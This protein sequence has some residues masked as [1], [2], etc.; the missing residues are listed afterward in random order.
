[1]P[2][3]S[4]TGSLSH[5]P[6]RT[7]NHSKATR[8]LHLP[9]VFSL[10]PR[11]SADHNKH[12]P[13]GKHLLRPRKHSFHSCRQMLCWASC[14]CLRE[15]PFPLERLPFAEVC[16]CVWCSHGLVC[17]VYVARQWKGR[18][19]VAWGRDGSPAGVGEGILVTTLCPSGHAPC[20][21][22][23]TRVCARWCARHALP[24]RGATQVSCLWLASILDDTLARPI[25]THP[26]PSRPPHPP[27]VP[28]NRRRYQG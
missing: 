2:F 16:A 25:I 3:C 11:S 7:Y 15:A 14:L 4:S 1:M 13:K 18:R 10:R 24:L 26:S 8:L 17:V 6:T 21:E 19:H 22:G 27:H 12:Y 9:G 20:H 5:I 23:S 28:T